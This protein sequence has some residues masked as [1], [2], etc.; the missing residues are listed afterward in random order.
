MFSQSASGKLFMVLDNADA[1]TSSTITTLATT[2]TG[3]ISVGSTTNWNTNGYLLAGNEVMSYTVASA[4][5][6][7]INTRGDL[8]T[9]GV[10]HATGATVTMLYSGIA[11]ND[12]LLPP[13]ATAGRPTFPAP[14]EFGFNTT[15]GQPEVWNGTT[16]ISTANPQLDPQGYLSPTAG[17]PIITGDATSQATIFYNPYKG[18]LL[19]VPTNGVFALTSFTTASIALSASQAVNGIYDVYGFIS[20]TNSTLTFGFSPSWSAGS[21]GSVGA[22]TGA[23]GTGAGGT[24]QTRLNGLLVNTTTMTILNG[25]SSYSI[26]TASGVFLG[27][28]I[29]SPTTAGTVN[30]HRSFGQTRQWGIWNAFNRVPIYLKAGDATSTWNRSGAAYRVYQ[31]NKWWNDRQRQS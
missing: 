9:T 25:A 31:A 16:W 26:A 6:L 22:G 7:T 5:G 24:A 19:P 17:T 23:R 1:T 15:L 3:A 29:V 14:G 12:F 30:L 18:N 13:R 27:S 4:A 11:K 28:I 2:G 10:T 20:T 21:G 8:G